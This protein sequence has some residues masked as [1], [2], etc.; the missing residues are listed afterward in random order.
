METVYQHYAQQEASQRFG[1]V[2]DGNMPFLHI[3]PRWASDHTFRK[4]TYFL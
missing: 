4:K 2:S 1:D 3:H